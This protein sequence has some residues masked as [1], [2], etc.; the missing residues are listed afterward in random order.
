MNKQYLLMT[1]ELSMAYLA[2]VMPG[3]RYVE[4]KGMPLKD[5]ADVHALVTPAPQP[6]PLENVTPEA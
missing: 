6:E 2:K 3:L 5:N 1:D 4:V